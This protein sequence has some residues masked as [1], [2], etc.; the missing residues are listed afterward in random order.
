MK[1]PFLYV[2]SLRISGM[3]PHF[4]ANVLFGISHIPFK[5]FIMASILGMS[6]IIFIYV[7]SGSTLMSLQNTGDI[8]T[9]KTLGSFALL[10]CLFLISILYKHFK[11]KHKN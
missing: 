6:P 9:G 5:T 2:F 4:I 3:V 1:S 7:Q 8:L 10:A 11:S